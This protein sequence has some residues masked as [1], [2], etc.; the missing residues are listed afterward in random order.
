MGDAGRNSKLEIR[1]WK[2]EIRKWTGKERAGLNL[3][4]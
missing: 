2:R 1:N 4:A 3:G